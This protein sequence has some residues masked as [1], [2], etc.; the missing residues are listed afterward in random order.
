MNEI[1]ATIKNNK[2]RT[3]LTAFGVFWGIFMIVLMLG[4]GNGLQHGVLKQ[5]GGMASNSFFIWGS[6]TSMPFMGMKPGRQIQMRYS[7]IIYLQQNLDELE[8]V[9]PMSQLG[10][11][12]G[13]NVVVHKNRYGNFAVV[14]ATPEVQQVQMVETTMGRF[15]K[16]SDLEQRR[17]IA[18]VGQAVVPILFANENPIGKTIKING[19]FFTVAGVYKSNKSDERAADEEN[20]LYIPFDTYL[21]A[22]NFGDKVEWIAATVKEGYS[23]DDAQRHVK[24]AL[25][26]RLKY[27][28]DDQQALGGWN[29]ASEMAKMTGLFSGIRIFNWVVGLLTLVAGIVGISNIMLIVVKERTKELGVRKALGATPSR[30][31]SMILLETILL[32]LAS[33]YLGIVLGVFAVENLNGVIAYISK[34]MN[35]NFGLDMFQNTGIDLGTAITALVILVVFGALAGLIPARQAVKINPI[36]ALRD[37]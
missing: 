9:V 21:H 32:T 4:I 19:V 7:D 12:R 3:L 20:Q 22:F 33:G 18:I 17:K 14:G 6:R 24:T 26:P 35:L 10:G 23:A 25:A 30:I 5:F 31:M 2:L 13:Q 11:F 1:L 36:E 8:Y 15:L 27:H 29:G 34:L 37:E 28:P 16:P